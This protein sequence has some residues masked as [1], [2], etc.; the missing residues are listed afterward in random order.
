MYLVHLN[1]MLRNPQG[2]KNLY[3]FSFVIQYRK[4]D[5][6]HSFWKRSIASVNCSVFYIKQRKTHFNK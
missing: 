5:N 6:Y 1:E 3:N 2:K 4:K